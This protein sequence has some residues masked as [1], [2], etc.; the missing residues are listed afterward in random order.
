[1]TNISNL[2]SNVKDIH[3]V[4]VPFLFSER[5]REVRAFP[6]LRDRAVKEGISL[7]RPY[8]LYETREIVSVVME[9][10]VCKIS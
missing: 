5:M 4:I 9:D 7:V 10:G 3:G 2:A 8:T 1:L 6:G